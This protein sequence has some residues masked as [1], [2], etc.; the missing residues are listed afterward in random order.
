MHNE[1]TFA[2]TTL[3]IAY[4]LFLFWCIAGW[5]RIIEWKVPESIQGNK[6]FVSVIIPARNEEANIID[7]LKDFIVQDFP[8]ASFE[9]IVVNDHSTDQT[10]GLVKKFIHDNAQFKISL[11]NM[12][13]DGDH[14]LYKKEAIT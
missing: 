1:L 13:D 8:P 12:D 5:M 14:V 7:C 10:Q 4:A 6:P 11:I 2:L 3:A 9:V